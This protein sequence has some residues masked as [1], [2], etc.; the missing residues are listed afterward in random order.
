MREDRKP[1]I[2]VIIPVFNIEQYMLECLESVLA[3]TY[4][5]YEV[6]LVDDGS[7][8]LSGSIC[9]EVS[10]SDSR[11]TVI[12][13]SNGGLSSA[14][15]T[16]NRFCTGE[17]AVYIDGDDYVS[18]Q[19]LEKMLSSAQKYDADLVICN[20]SEFEDNKKL[21]GISNIVEDSVISPDEVQKKLIFKDGGEVYSI[22]CNKLFRR[23]LLKKII[24]PEQKLHEDEYVFHDLYFNCQRVSQIKDALYF[25]RQRSGSIMNSVWTIRRL[26]SVEAFLLRAKA[27]NQHSGFEKT[28]LD[29]MNR[30]LTDYEEYCNRIHWKLDSAHRTRNEKLQELYG[31]VVPPFFPQMRAPRK[32]IYLLMRYNFFIGN[33]MM[34]GLNRLVD[35]YRRK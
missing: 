4:G 14:R 8:D 15:N 24:F 12:H 17:Y 34:Y 22:I 32:Y 31:N 20:Y 21:Q 26:D 3:Q 29:T 16:G 19:M 11:I 23:D 1:K 5:N 18:P 13:K 2:S 7:K 6:I 33:K 27:Y 25:Y 28:A 10:V 9:D 30:A 35:K